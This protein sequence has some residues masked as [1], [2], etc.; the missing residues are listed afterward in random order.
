MT[1][2]TFLLLLNTMIP[3]SLIVTIEIV[4]Y[5]QAF[6][7]NWDAEMYSKIKERFAQ[8]NSCSLNEELGQ[9]KYIFSDKTGTLTANKLEFTACA[10]GNE[11]FGMTEEE[12]ENKDGKTLSKRKERLRANME[13]QNKAVP[14]VYTFPDK[15]I[16]EYSCGNKEG[17]KFDFI[18]KSLSGKTTMALDTTQKVIQMFLYC[19]CLNHTCFVEKTPKPGVTV[20]EPKMIRT[21]TKMCL[22][23]TSTLGAPLKEK[24]DSVMSLNLVENYDKY[25]ISYSGENPDEIILVDTARRLGFVYLGGDETISN[26]RL[27]TEVNGNV[28]SG[29][30]QKWTILCFADEKSNLLNTHQ[31]AQPLSDLRA[32]LQVHLLRNVT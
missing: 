3:I 21:N 25:N 8:C 28:I 29:R 12:L 31:Q 13:P 17:E 26:I 27:N 19:L 15:E 10:V 11:I 9:I 20:Q 2:W 14:I 1:F 18:I 5:L 30:N 24:L 22:E 23:K 6:L 4:K 16:K 32:I 7:M